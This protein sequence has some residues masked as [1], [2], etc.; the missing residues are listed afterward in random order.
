MRRVSLGGRLLFRRG[1]GLLGRR[2]WL[3]LLLGSRLGNDVSALFRSGRLL[4]LLGSRL[5]N[6]LS[7]TRIRLFVSGDSLGFLSLLSSGRL[8]LGLLLLR[9]LFQTRLLL[10]LTH[11]NQYMQSNTQKINNSNVH[12]PQTY[13][14]HP[15]PPVWP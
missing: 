5:D 11:R 1:L 10:R 15:T 3:L 12:S 2:H 14:P 8:A 7:S 4:L 9:G 6:G 13:S